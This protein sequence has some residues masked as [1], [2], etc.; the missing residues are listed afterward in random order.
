MQHCRTINVVFCMSLALVL[1]HHRTYPEKLG[2]VQSCTLSRSS[3]ISSH[4]QLS[5]PSVMNC[6]SV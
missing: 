6:V 3:F 2:V 4:W 5:Q 1:E